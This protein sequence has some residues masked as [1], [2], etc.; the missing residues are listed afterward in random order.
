MVDSKCHKL[1]TSY[2]R[3]RHSRDSS[4]PV[5]LFYEASEQL[6]GWLAAGLQ[7]TPQLVLLLLVPVI[8]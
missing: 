8:A 4:V 5:C 1:T 6:T 3:D 2:M 7:L